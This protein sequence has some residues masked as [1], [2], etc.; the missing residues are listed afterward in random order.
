M[1]SFRNIAVLI[2]SASLL[3]S[4]NHD[5]GWIHK[6]DQPRLEYAPNMYHAVT[7]EPL[8]QITDKEAGM[9]VNSD[10]DNVGEYYNSNPYNPNDMTMRV[11]PATSIPRNKHG[12]LPY[13]IPKDSLDYAAK[14]LQNP[15]PDSPEV[16]EDGKQLFVK[17]CSHC[18]G[19][20]GA[21][22]GP[23]N[24][25]LHG[26]ANLT[27]PQSKTFTEGHIFHVITW[28]KG[29]MGSHASQLN[30]EERWKIARYVK[31]VLQKQ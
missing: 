27:S 4:C 28:G 19:E 2:F 23:V 11:P 1:T 29:R 8:S 3:S 5:F 30:Q 6:H 15:I 7:Y 24:D 20:T 22:D 9:W 13:R 14:V 31:E 16:L 21:G 12:F 25:V 26:V 18:H 10:G 17:F